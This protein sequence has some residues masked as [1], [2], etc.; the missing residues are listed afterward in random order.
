[1]SRR[2]NRRQTERVRQIVAERE[3]A[4]RPDVLTTLRR[5]GE[6]GV[7]LGLIYALVR[8][9]NQAPAVIGALGKGMADAIRATVEGIG[10]PLYGPYRPPEQYCGSPERH[11]AHTW[12]PERH[13]SDPCAGPDGELDCLPDCDCDCHTVEV[14]GALLCRGTVDVP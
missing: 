1:M 13:R 8:P 10:R 9:G 14:V 11:G 4:A 5:A 6:A 3:A 7:A 12:V 2:R